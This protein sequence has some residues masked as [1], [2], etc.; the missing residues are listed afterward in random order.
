M[1]EVRVDADVSKTL[2]ELTSQ[3]FL[4]DEEGR[5]LGSFSPWKDHPKFSD[6]QLEPP[7]SLE[8][9]QERRKNPTGKPLEEILARLGIQ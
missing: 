9:L 6:L 3:A 4:C 5:V 1:K 2:C 7:S 8:E